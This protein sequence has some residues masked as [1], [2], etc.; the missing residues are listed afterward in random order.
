MQT[1]LDWFKPNKVD[2]VVPQ[3]ALNLYHD[4][5]SLEWMHTGNVC[6]FTMW[7]HPDGELDEVIIGWE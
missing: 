5:F 1:T 2:I 7:Y 6:D 3:L 4:C